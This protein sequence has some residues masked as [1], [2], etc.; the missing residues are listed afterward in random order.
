MTSGS[1]TASAL[2]E[3]EIV[4]A[5]LPM[6]RRDRARPG[7]SLGDDDVTYATPAGAEALDRMS[8]AQWLDRAGV[9]GWL[10]KLLDVAYTTE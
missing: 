2:S 9:A 8:I 1:S 6:A 10:R 5:F 3:R 4:E 7:R